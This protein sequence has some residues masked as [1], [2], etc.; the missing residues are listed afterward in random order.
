MD[1]K[2]TIE[3]LFNSAPLFQNIGAGAYKEGLYNT[4]VLDEHFA[5][6]HLSFKTIHVA[7]TNG[8]GS[9][10]HT[11]ASV[12]Q[13]AGYKVGLYTSPHLVDFRERIRVNGKP[14]SEQYVIDFVEHERA[15][16]EPLH[17][18]FFELTTAMAFK[19]FADEK[20]DV[21]VIEVGL[22]GR[23]DCTN[24]I[25]PDVSII[26]NISFDH[27][28]FLGD[29][30]AKIAS[31]KAGIIKP[32][33]P[34]VIGETTPETKPVFISKAEEQNAPIIFAE[35]QD[36]VMGECLLAKG[37]FDYQTKTFG[38]ITAELGGLCQT[39]NTRTIIEA[40]KQLIGK[41]YRIT[42]QNVADGF[43]S[44]CKNTGLMG[45]WQ[46]LS[47]KPKVICDT[48]HNVGG[49]QYIVKQ[50]ELQ[51]YDNLRIVMGMVNDKDIS[52]VLSMMPKHAVYYFTQASVKR[53]M[54][55]RDFK[56]KAAGYGLEGDAYPTVRQA[57]EAALHDASQNDLVFVGGSSFIVADLLSF[58]K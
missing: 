28:Q 10:S 32:N 51:E 41:G 38:L 57:Y 24:I 17:P 2:E 29:T 3:Y 36:E 49:I 31:E 35:E 45:R 47:D 44:V 21:A 34:V 39:K 19:F 26:T 5:H 50:L 18:S 37:G 1:Y 46:K 56:A 14:I 20:V 54:P 15:F 16:F 42:R 23:L 52:T 40:L 9:C 7:G 55:C 43:A 58:L 11:I 27:V 8:K 53:A 13:E 25:T 4:K 33:I 22:G 30:L 48:G 12:L 6:P